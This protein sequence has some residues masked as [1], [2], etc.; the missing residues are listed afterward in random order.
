MQSIDSEIV[1]RKKV[2]SYNDSN[3]FLNVFNITGTI[4]SINR[5]EHCIELLLSTKNSNYA[6]E[7]EID[8]PNIPSRFRVGD[9][10]TCTGFV[11]GVAEQGVWRIRF[12]GK[13]I[14]EV[15]ISDLGDEALDDLVR[16]MELPYQTSGD[17][18]E[19][20]S[21]V[22]YRRAKRARR[23]GNYVGLSGFVDS[24]K[25]YPGK[26]ISD[27]GRKSADSVK[28]LLRQFEDVNQNIL[29]ELNGRE[30]RQTYEGIGKLSLMGIPFIRFHGE[31]Y[32]KIKDVPR[33]VA[34]LDGEGNP[35]LDGQQQPVF[36]NEVETIITQSIKA[37]ASI[38]VGQAHHCRQPKVV[39]DAGSD[40][41]RIEYPYPWAVIYK[42][43]A[44]AL[45]NKLQKKAGAAS[46]ARVSQN[47]SD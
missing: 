41:E 7:I 38:G 11:R 13:E 47:D 42:E 19:R 45:Q 14:N 27:D 15:K 21:T 9:L 36:E 31:A 30:A 43:R 35:V 4:K 32:V 26:Q 34:V 10:V 25:F 39:K 37:I 20:L 33:Q 1:H 12:R 23:N 16:R 29:V 17:K 8:A 5:P 40:E 2:R 6:L 28:I 24:M 18:T 3:G 44:E 46:R 22:E